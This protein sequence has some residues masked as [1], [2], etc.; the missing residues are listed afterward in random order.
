VI[1]CLA[2]PPV[3]E[4]VV[5]LF[6]ACAQFRTAPLKERHW[7]DGRSAAAA[8][9]PEVEQDGVFEGEEAPREASIPAYNSKPGALATL[10]LDFSKPEEAGQDPVDAPVRPIASSS[11]PSSIE[12]RVVIEIWQA[13]AAKFAHRNVN[14]TTVRPDA[15]A[16]RSV[17][18]VAVGRMYQECYRSMLQYR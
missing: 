10:Y 8:E 9:W 16:D 15:G 3:E 1:A 14:V 2:S 12:A 5:P 17:R 6:L 7:D 11:T 4:R 13:I 18:R